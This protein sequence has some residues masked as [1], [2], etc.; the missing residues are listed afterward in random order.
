MSNNQQCNFA[1]HDQRSHL[2][3]VITLAM[4]YK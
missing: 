1:L 4:R 2:D 3:K